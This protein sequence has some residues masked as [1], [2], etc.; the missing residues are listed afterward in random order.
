MAQTLAELARALGGEVVGDPDLIIHGAAPLADVASGQITFIDQ[1][2]RIRELQASAAAATLVPHG[3]AH[4]ALGSANAKAIELPCPAIRVADVHQSFA[5]LWTWF[6]PP[7]PRQRRGVSPRADVSPAARLAA[8]VEVHA[9]ATIDDDVEIGPGCT[10]HAGAH[11]M[12]GCRLSEAVTVFPGAVLYENTLVGPRCLL[13]AGAVIGSYGFGYRLIDGRHVRAPQYGYVEL[14][15]DVEV[16]AN[17]TI[18]R[19]TFGRTWI[20]DG[21]KIDNQVQIAHNCRLGRHNLICSQVGIAGSTTTGDYVVMAGQCG[22]RDHVHIGDRAVLA[23][24]SGITN[25]VPAG[26]CMLGIPATPEREQKVK[27]AALS[28]LPEMRRELRQLQLT[29]QALEARLAGEGD[30]KAA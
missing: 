19:G 29:V 28:K 7:L 18:D 12:R 6:Y 17:S 2:T 3:W 22:V 15:A 9:G 16:G 26:A 11:L 5:A 27:L 1:P 4:A 30:A 14:G 13:H 10:I 23:A 21:T 25:D 20:A 8:D 24:M